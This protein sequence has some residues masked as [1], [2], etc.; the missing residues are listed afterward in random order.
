MQTEWC[1]AAT[2]GAYIARQLPRLLWYVGHGYVMGRLAERARAQNGNSERRPNRTNAPVLDRRRLYR[3]MAALF[4]TDLA[5]VEAGL[6]PLPR[7]RDGS[8]LTLLDR[9]GLFF[10]DLPRVHRRRKA[11]EHAE[12]LN[13]ETRGR[14]PDYYLQN[15]H[16]QTGGWMT[17]D[18]G[19]SAPTGVVVEI[20]R[21][22][23]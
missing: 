17:E 5:N 19:W 3:D 14:R 18:I 11:G 10:E 9:S 13:E 16:F 8:L 12:V 21:A 1:L 23:V 15:F 6:Y 2:R 4:R 20:G 7:D 22:H